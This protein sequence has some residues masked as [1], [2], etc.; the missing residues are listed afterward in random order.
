MRGCTSSS[1]TIATPFYSRCQCACKGTSHWIISQFGSDVPLVVRLGKNCQLDTKPYLLDHSFTACLALRRV[2]HLVLSNIE[3]HLSTTFMNSTA[4]FVKQNMKQWWWARGLLQVANEQI[5][6]A[7][8]NQ[9]MGPSFDRAWHWM[10]R[11][12]CEKLAPQQWDLV[13]KMPWEAWRGLDDE[14]KSVQNFVK[15]KGQATQN[16][17][18]ACHP[19]DLQRK[20]VCFASMAWLCWQP[21][22]AYCDPEWSLTG[23]SC[24]TNFLLITICFRLVQVRALIWNKPFD[25]NMRTCSIQTP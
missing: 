22:S 20:L 19:K 10:E 4:M 18:A 17:P 14:N 11:T 13:P 8:S 12:K 24:H 3:V 5:Q 21:Q 2:E 23:A 15:R 16:N 7:A 25:G 9:E 6:Y 1:R